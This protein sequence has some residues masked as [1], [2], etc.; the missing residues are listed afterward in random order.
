MKQRINKALNK[1][2][3]ITALIFAFNQENISHKILLLIMA[4]IVLVKDEKLE[5]T[6]IPKKDNLKKI[7]S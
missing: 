3:V 1:I 5:F 4:F 6:G 2:F 7:F